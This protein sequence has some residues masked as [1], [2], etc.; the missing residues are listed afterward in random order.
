MTTDAK[1]YFRVAVT[2]GWITDAQGRYVRDCI[3]HDC[4]HNHR[5][6][7]AA[8]ACREK[9]LNWDKERKNCSAKWY[10]SQVL[11][12]NRNGQHVPAPD[13]L[14]SGPGWCAECGVSVPEKTGQT[15]CPKHEAK[16][17]E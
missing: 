5:T 15:L 2:D 13:P 10:N 17:S 11:P 12:T 1:T 6:E 9:L 7:Q 8:E 16:Y 14:N 4:G 3:I